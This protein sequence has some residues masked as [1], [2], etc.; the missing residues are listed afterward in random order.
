VKKIVIIAASLVLVMFFFSCQTAKPQAGLDEESEQITEQNEVNEPRKDSPEESSIQSDSD[1]AVQDKDTT[2][3]AAGSSQIS[4]PDIQNKEEEF[5]PIKTQEIKPAISSA[6]EFIPVNDDSLV[7]ELTPKKEQNENRIVK[8]ILR[9][10]TSA[11]TSAAAKIW[12]PQEGLQDTEQ[13]ETIIAD[14]PIS[15]DENTKQTPVLPDE[16][17]S[18]EDTGGIVQSEQ[19]VINFSEVLSQQGSQDSIPVQKPEISAVETQQPLL[20]QGDQALQGQKDQTLLIQP[21]SVQRETIDS[22]DSS[23]QNQNTNPSDGETLNSVETRQEEALP[24]VTNFS[25]SR[26]VEVKNNQY[27]D[28]TYPGSGWVYIGEEGGKSLLNYFGRKTDK[29][30]TVFTLRT[31]ESGN[32]LLHFYKVDAL[33]GSYIDDYLEVIVAQENSSQQERVQVPLYEMSNALTPP[34]SAVQKDESTPQSTIPR[35]DQLWSS[36]VAAEPDVQILF[37]DENDVSVLYDGLSSTQLLEEAKN[38][39]NNAEYK[40]AL[41]ILDEFLRNSVNDLDEAW[42][43]KG[44]IYETPSDQRN[45]RKAVEAYELLTKA[46][47]SSPLW[48][49]AKDRITYLEKFYFSIQ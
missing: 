22:I 12:N 18:V 46:Y 21:S 8:P 31:K 23:V 32:T 45:I 3:T 4:P 41:D 2:V 19:P 28:V 13:D 43:L 10:R 33:S 25:P 42:F 39:Y 14:E 20:P 36:P 17:G 11:D 49:R 1:E 40:K 34:D 47:P 9:P 35:Q 16:G 30:N 15:G 24:S 6:D 7:I 29:G 26:T 38:A 48:K 5:I 44:Q 37:P 27:I